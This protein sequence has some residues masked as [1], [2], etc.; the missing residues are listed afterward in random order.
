M[1]F[2]VNTRAYQR[3]HHAADVVP[4][5]VVF[6]VPSQPPVYTP[7]V[8]VDTA[9]CEE[10]VRAVQ[11]VVGSGPGGACVLCVLWPRRCVCIV[12]A[13][14][15]VRVR[16]R[17]CVCVCAWRAGISNLSLFRCVCV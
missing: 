5:H 14:V 16:V 10:Q 4:G 11:M 3:M 15:R 13:R 7:V 6:P 9:L 2:H 17:V 8:V 12:C 1:L